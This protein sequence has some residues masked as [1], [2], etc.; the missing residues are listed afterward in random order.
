M[1]E[2]N[3]NLNNINRETIKSN[4]STNFYNEIEED[5]VEIVNLSDDYQY[6]DL[7]FK[8]IVIGNSGVGKTCITNQATKLKF[9][10]CYKATVGMEFYSLS[11]KLNKILIKLQIWDT[12]GQET[13]R[14]LITNFYRSSSLGVMV[15][16]I[17]DL[18]SFNDL[19]FWMKEI[20]VNNSPDT[21][22]ILVGNKLDKNNERKVKFEEG[23]NYA[24]SNGFEEFFETSAKTGEN[25]RKMFIKVA[26]ILYDDY[27][28]YKELEM[29]D[30]FSSYAAS[31]KSKKP[32]DKKKSKNQKNE[33]KNKSKNCC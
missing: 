11:V 30:S 33:K 8:I 9:D 16:A 6:Y 14:S 3:D 23:K 12:C 24:K 4:N 5:G 22:L 26:K 25:V 28:K 7:S 1:E 29:N 10:D 2:N 13:Y 21:K 32:N 20:K 17:D 31:S 27:K 19:D 18:K 15:Y